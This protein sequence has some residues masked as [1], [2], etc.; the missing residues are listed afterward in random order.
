MIQ[1]NHYSKAIV[2]IAGLVLLHLAGTPIDGV[3]EHYNTA[4]QYII[5]LLTAW[6]V[7]EAKNQPKK[8]KK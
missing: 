4:A 1:L 8:R 5:S 6:G 3:N 2:A 7:F